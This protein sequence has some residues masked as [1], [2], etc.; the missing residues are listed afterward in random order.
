VLAVV[1]AMVAAARY[2]PRER[3]QD[4]LYKVLQEHLE[5]F[6]AQVSASGRTL[7][8]YVE[9]ELRGYLSCG[10]PAHGFTLIRCEDCEHAQVLGFSCKGRGFCPSCGGRRMAQTAAHL[11]D[12]VLPHVPVRQWVLTM[13]MPVRL[14]LARR[15]R[16]LEDVLG[17]F[18]E[19]VS[20]WYQGQP[21]CAGGRTGAVTFVQTAGSTLRLNVHFH[22]L[23]LDGCYVWDEESGKPAFVEAGALS[24]ADVQALVEAVEGRV[25][26]VLRR[27]GLL[28]DEQ[29]EDEEDA[30]LALQAAS[31]SGRVALGLR[32]GRRPR[33]K[34]GLMGNE[35]KMPARCAESGY[36]N[37][38]A[39]VRI[40]AR[41]RIAL[42]RL[43]RYVARPP[44]A[45][46]RLSVQEDGGVELR[47]K[48][49][50]SDGTR[51]VSYGPLAFIARLAALVV[52]PGMHLVRYHGVLASAAKW[53]SLVV[54]EHEASACVP[55]ATRA[56]RGS[57]WIPWR[58][59]VKRVFGVDPLACPKCGGAMR[60]HAVVRGP[61]SMSYVL[62]CLGLPA[63]APPIRRARL[64]D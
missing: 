5:T 28:E 18:V 64:W 61:G 12:E 13:P 34:R 32:A 26:R 10:I 15:P 55:K 8:W 59:L 23:V 37:L 47:F 4:V 38:H 53:R 60:V 57:R 44:L 39:N 24:T 27:H 1:D 42:E 52:R 62:G 45:L 22:T 31:V 46:S 29:D 35:Y 51:A 11:V 33:C 6:L 3:G 43:C 7:P 9:R 48:R 14:W 41:D 2:V 16:L 56:P 19:V 20:C 54:P 30:Q 17:V 63:R 49:A 21:G 25:R 40:A 50:W 58:D 36:Y